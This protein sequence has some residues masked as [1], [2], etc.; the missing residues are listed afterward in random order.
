[1]RKRCLRRSETL[2][3]SPGSQKVFIE[4]DVKRILTP[5]SFFIS[6]PSGLRMLLVCPL[7]QR[8]KLKEASLI[9]QDTVDKLVGP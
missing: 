3:P 6:S 7:P 9:L 5:L 2:A 1:M 8:K 4:L